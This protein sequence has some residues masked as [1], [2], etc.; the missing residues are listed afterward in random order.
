MTTFKHPEPCFHIEWDE[1]GFGKIFDKPS[2]HSVPGWGE[3][4]I[5]KYKEEIARLT[6][7]IFH[8]KETE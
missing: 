2:E 8:F 5:N 3:R 4:A 7:M 1:N 6:P